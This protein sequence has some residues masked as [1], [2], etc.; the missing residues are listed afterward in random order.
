MAKIFYS[1]SG[2]GR[3]HATRVRAIV[4]LLAPEHTI[5]IFAPGDAYDLLA[6]AYAGTAVH[7]EPLPG[8]RFF[9]TPEGKLDSP[10]TLLR[11]VSYIA[12][13]PLLLRKLRAIMR[14][15]KP[16]LIITDFEPSLPRAARS[17]GIPFLSLNHQHFLI[18][19]DLSILPP[20][21]RRR[22]S[23]IALVVRSY[24]GVP[25]H[26]VVS[27]FYKP[28][29]KEKYRRQVTPA[30]VILRPAVL[31]QTPTREGHLLCYMRKF[32]SENVLAAL[33]TCGM[34]VR[35]YG[36]GERP[37][38]GRLEFRAI[39]ES[40]FLR[41]LASCEALISTAGNQLVGEALYL[42]K[43]VLAMPEPNNDEQIINAVFLE[44]EG[45]GCWTGLAD[46]DAMFL[47]EFLERLPEFRE[48]IV[49]ENYSGNTAALAKIRSMLAAKSS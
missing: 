22:A 15:E 43:P 11:S 3:G 8:L 34:P 46:L 6:P 24:Y 48:R 17:L 47:R 18:V 9:Y 21:L 39:S 33:E 44:R 2:E 4:D 35:L 45:T 27:S 30:G 16:D 5:R 19:N 14:A 41:D 40:H 49:P 20:W 25:Q 12:R 42:G 23:L 37:A 29:V 1:M 38:R 26:M 32:S 13:F 31:A 10:Q 7:V 28:P 36:L